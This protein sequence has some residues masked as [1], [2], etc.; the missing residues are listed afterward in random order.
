VSSDDV[1]TTL[2]LFEGKVMARLDAIDS[3]L[4]SL[5]RKDHDRD[6]ETK[7]MWERVLSEFTQMRTDVDTHLT[8]FDRKLDI[9]NKEMLQLKADHIGMEGRVSKIELE[10]HPSVIIQDRG[11]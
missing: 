4:A 11:F 1:A 5:E 9:I 10:I 2:H 8:N 3:R 7:P 6:F